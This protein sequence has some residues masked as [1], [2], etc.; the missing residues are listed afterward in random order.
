MDLQTRIA[1][2]LE[3]ELSKLDALSQAS[4]DPMQS[5]DIRS[6]DTLIKAHKAF[7][8]ADPVPPSSPD[9]PANKSTDEL[10]ASLSD[11]K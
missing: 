1:K 7:I 5:A 10:I 11:H 9:A 8:A 3:R 2:I 4:S 6:L